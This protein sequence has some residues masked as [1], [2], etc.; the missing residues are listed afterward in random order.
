MNALGRSAVVYFLLLSPAVHAQYVE[1]TVDPATVQLR[2]PAAVYTLLIHGR[3]ADGRL[4]DRTR[5]ARFR[6]LDPKVAAVSDAGV[7]RASETA[8][9]PSS[10]TLTANP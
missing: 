4:V 6:S 9:P 1:T 3:T 2:G 8:G 7:V 5:N 10:R